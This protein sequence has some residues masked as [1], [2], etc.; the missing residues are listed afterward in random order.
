[1]SHRAWGFQKKKIAQRL[2]ALARRSGANAR[3][4]HGNVKNGAMNFAARGWI[5]K[6]KEGGISG[7]SGGTPG[8][9][10]CTPYW[11]NDDFVLEEV[12]TVGGEAIEV[13]VYHVGKTGVE[14]DP[15]A[16]ILAKEVSGLPV[17]DTV[18]CDDEDSS[19]G[20]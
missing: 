15:K 16:Y 8:S 3:I 20:S 10:A 11:I 19:S 6:T 14:H 12:R 18:F 9:G 1:M 17:V 7:R 5:F 2:E 4:K 13:T